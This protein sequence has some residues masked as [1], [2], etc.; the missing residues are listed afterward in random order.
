M[1]VPIVCP[2]LGESRVR[3]GV[4]SA[5]VGTTVVQGEPLVDV[6][7]PGL[8]WTVAA[9]RDGRLVEICVRDRA[10]LSGGDVLGWLA[11]GDESR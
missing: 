8:C 6:V 5:A 11:S 10:T 9:P 4:W 2:E 3:V 1:R 7:L